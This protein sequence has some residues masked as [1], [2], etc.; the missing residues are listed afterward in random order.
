[1]GRFSFFT[2]MVSGLFDR[3]PSAETAVSSDKIEALAQT[4]LSSQGEVSGMRLSRE[5]LSRYRALTAKQKLAF[6]KWLAKSQ[7]LDP[8]KAIAAATAYRDKRDGDSYGA[9]VRAAEPPRQELLR[10]LNQPA[11]ATLELVRMR[12][13]LLGFLR[14]HPELEAIDLDFRHLFR[15]WFNRGFLVLRPIGWQSPANILEKI[16]EYEA[17]HT[18]NDW[19]DLRRRLLPSD[20]RCFAF[21]HPAMLDEP[22]IF[23]EVALCQGIPGSV[24]ALLAEDRAPLPESDLDTAVF[25]SISNCQAGLRGISFGN[26]L[27]KQV[28]EELRAEL[29]QIRTTITLSPIPGLMGWLRKQPEPIASQIVAAAEKGDLDALQNLADEIRLAAATWLAQEKAANGQPADPVARFHLGN[30]AQL[31][32]VHALADTSSNGLRQSATAMVN[33]LY[34]LSQVEAN[35]EAFATQKRVVISKEIKSLLS[36][37][38]KSGKSKK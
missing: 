9:F 16:I 21:F 23:V 7:D 2:D 11:G 12:H 27:I 20:R 34:D 1:M 8:D 29:P 17:V 22:L 37:P 3:A 36:A 26:S 10:R 30:G 18:I 24:Q 25:Y 6:F 4:L 33:Y 5:V 19:S 28:V 32:Q 13:D 31:H 15:S 38:T 35:H 14:E